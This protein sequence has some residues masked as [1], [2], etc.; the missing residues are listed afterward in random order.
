MKDL[1]IIGAGPAGLSAGIYAQRAGLD[2]ILLEKDYIA[3]GQVV[4]TYEVANYP[5]LNGISG[6]DLSEKFEEHFKA[7]GGVSVTDEV[8]SIEENAGNYKVV[9]ENE[10]YDTKGV[11]LALGATHAHLGCKGEEEFAGMGV[12][13][14]ATCDGAFF[15]GKDVAVVGGG[16]VAVEDA[17]FL[18]RICRKVYIIHR[19]DEFRAVA[20]LVNELKSYENV[21]FVYDSVVTEIQ[22][23]NKVSA[24]AVNNKKTGENKTIE[25]SGVFIAV[26]IIPTSDKFQA[27]VETDEKG[28]IVAGEDCRTSK[29]RIYA[30]GDVRGKQLR[31][32]ITAA[33][34]GANAI[35]SFSADINK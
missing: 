21:E 2:A 3:G 8:V 26:G 1:V 31:Q 30:C 35:T 22:G 16:D 6:A 28:Y 13:Y 23:D 9:C 27:F 34:D 18:A 15:R 32:I 12:S 11:I 5:G 20:S 29:E 19:R 24:V 14:C 7:L 17:I 10:T 4:N 33:A 25:V